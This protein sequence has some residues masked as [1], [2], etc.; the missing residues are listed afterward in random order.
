MQPESQ[1]S[2]TR[3]NRRPFSFELEA[4]L[5]KLLWLW[6]PVFIVDSVCVDSE[7]RVVVDSL[8]DLKV[9]G[10]G[11]TCVTAGNLSRCFVFF[12]VVG[13]GM[14]LKL[15]WLLHPV[16]IVDFGV[17]QGGSPLRE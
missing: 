14:P 6:K 9:T 4:G 12:G 13:C 10:R 7:C 15:L 5:L 16:L 17:W 11:F 8:C 2:H 3:S 1:Q